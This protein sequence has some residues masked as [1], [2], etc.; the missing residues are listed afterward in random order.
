MTKK[1]NTLVGLKSEYEVTVDHLVNIG[2]YQTLMQYL[3]PPVDTKGK[4]VL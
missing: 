4:L 1:L 2:E 3:W